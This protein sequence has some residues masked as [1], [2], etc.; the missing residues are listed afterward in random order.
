MDDSYETFS[1]SK[2]LNYYNLNPVIQE[3]NDFL[4]STLNEK[5]N[6]C[7]NESNSQF[8]FTPVIEEENGDFFIDDTFSN[9]V[10]QDDIG[11]DNEDIIS[12]ITN[13]T[14]T[15]NNNNNNNNNYNY[16]Y[17]DNYNYNNNNNNN[18]TLL[19]HVLNYVNVHINIYNDNVKLYKL[20]ADTLEIYFNFIFSSLRKNFDK[21]IKSI[22]DLQQKD[23]Q[24][25]IRRNY[26][27]LLEYIVSV[28][29]EYE[30][31]IQ[32]KIEEI[33]DYMLVIEKKLLKY[34]EILTQ[35]IWHCHYLTFL[36][37]N[38]GIEFYENYNMK[39]IFDNV[40]EKFQIDFKFI[41]AVLLNK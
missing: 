18:N 7:V 9:N 21:I 22:Q 31:Y 39:Q 16:N 29:M 15:N 10:L 2:P 3:S 26:N 36:P 11:I 37:S 17:N 23:D 14:T 13:T 12:T 8:S 19:N 25:E 24:K 6:E 27:S 38:N 40:S 41:Y 33:K 4:S 28:Y 30:D 34:S 32:G 20:S 1:Y 5:S 35:V